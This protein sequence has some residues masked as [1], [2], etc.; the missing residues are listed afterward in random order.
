MHLV[1]KRYILA[2]KREDEV[3]FGRSFKSQNS[4][5][6]NYLKKIRIFRNRNNFIPFWSSYILPP[7]PL[8]FS[9][10]EVIVQAIINGILFLVQKVI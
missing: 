7:F 1:E 8:S 10:F 3:I 4:P 6:G 9:L 5:R 2:K